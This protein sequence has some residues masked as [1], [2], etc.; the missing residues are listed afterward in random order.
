M[1]IL[2]ALLWLLTAA[3]A[4]VASG[5]IRLC[6]VE[7]PAA[8]CPP[9]DLTELRLQGKEAVL[10]RTI[11]VEPAA[12]PLERTIGVRIIAMASSEVR[13]N[14]TVIGRNGVPGP[15]ARH[16]EPGRFIAV[17]SV[18]PQLVRAGHNVVTVRLSSH[19]L[20]L[21]VQRPVHSF[22][23]APFEGETLPGLTDYLPALLMLGALA[24]ACIYF[25]AAAVAERRNR[26]PL[27]LALIAAAGLLQ[28]TAEVSRTFVA[29]TYPWHLARVGLIALLAA[30][31][32]VLA[33]AYAALRFA[34]GRRRLLIV[35][36]TIAAA[37]SVLLIPWYDLK[38]LGAIM[39]GA[40]AI[41]A[42]GTS[43][44]KR[45]DRAGWGAVAV[46]ATI[47]LLIAWQLVSF[48]DSAWFILLA[49]VL[50]LLV[51]E[52]VHSLRRAR[53]E[54]DEERRRSA[55]L[56]ERLALAEHRGV[57][58]LA[59]KNGSRT[60]RVAETDILFIRAADDYCE[61]MLADGRIM[62]V[63]MTLSRLLATLPTRFLRVHKSYAVNRAH[64]A[65]LKPKSGGGRMLELS[66]GSEVPVGRSY[67]ERVT[68]VLGNPSLSPP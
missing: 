58:I 21:P 9:I 44:I 59:L 62:L 10:V 6:P 2:L 7:A 14:G 36:T 30:G 55:A 11:T 16:E 63:T 37:A 12:L 56:A 47:P 28:L 24:A 22:E 51:A 1:P 29:Y 19:H 18:P 57:P 20:W 61:A 68:A 23:V 33:A 17:F 3:A 39:A 42:A 8:D 60:H 32:A 4:P 46:A 67:G 31:I 66:D 15:D 5:P 49:A 38:A 52:Q 53:A 45:K 34:P 35:G 25:A 41:A 65:S 40:V 64:V 50:V 43:G 54:R 27:L 13:W 26:A 48:L